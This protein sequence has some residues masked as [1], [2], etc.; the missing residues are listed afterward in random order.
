MRLALTLHLPLSARL[1]D[2]AVTL[3]STVTISKQTTLAVTAFAY[4]DLMAAEGV[5]LYY[6]KP[7]ARWHW[8]VLRT[9]EE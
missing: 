8:H 5:A 6:S 7:W 2:R 9:A 1:L 4:E 3:L